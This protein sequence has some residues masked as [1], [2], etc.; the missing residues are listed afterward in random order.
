MGERERER[1]STAEENGV[2]DSVIILF[3][4]T[5]LEYLDGVETRR[6]VSFL[7]VVDLDE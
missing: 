6:T 5:P 1:G 7:P 3:R 2:C 4:E